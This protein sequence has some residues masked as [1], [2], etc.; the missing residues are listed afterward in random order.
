MESGVAGSPTSR[1]IAGVQQRRQRIEDY[2]AAS[3]YLVR[4]LPTR[5][6][7]DEQARLDA[8][9]RKTA[10]VRSELTNLIVD[11]QMRTGTAQTDVALTDGQEVDRSR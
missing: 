3:G 2:Q 10:E 4:P 1:G 8:I 9:R 11:F 7:A 6:S 5:L